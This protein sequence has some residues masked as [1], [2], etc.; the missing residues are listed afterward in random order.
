MTSLA[1][2]ARRIEQ[3]AGRP[4]GVF[5]EAWE[6]ETEDGMRRFLL[7]RPP[8][9]PD[10]PLPVILDVHGSGLDAAAQLLTSGAAHRARNSAVVILPQAA[11]PFR[12]RPDL[13]AGWAWNVPGSPLP[14]EASVRPG[15]PDDIGFLTALLGLA[16]DLSPSGLSGVHLLGFSGGARLCCRLALEAGDTVTSIAV[17]AG[18]R[19]PARPPSGS[20]RVLAVHGWQDAVNPYP[21]GQDPRWHEPVPDAAQSWALALGCAPAPA[22]ERP[23]PALE[24][25]SWSAGRTERVRLLTLDRA[26]HCWPGS[27]DTGHHRQFG[28]CD[29]ADATGAALDF[30]GIPEARP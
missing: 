11:I 29:D 16:A 10:H 2:S 21:G 5:T 15:L 14:G 27:R 3:H 18:L 1:G 26:G 17:V 19:P 13:P 28:R 20:L 9:T 22:V 7:S 24:T 6:T 25:R 23:S 4:P 30:F 8:G 12:L